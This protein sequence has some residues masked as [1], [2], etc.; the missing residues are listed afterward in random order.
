MSKVGIEAEDGRSRVFT[1]WS[2]QEV[3]PFTARDEPG[4]LWVPAARDR[5]DHTLGRSSRRWH[6]INLEAIGGEACPIESAARRRD[7]SWRR[8]HVGA[9]AG[10]EIQEPELAVTV[11][12]DVCEPL[13][14]ER[15][16]TQGG[17]EVG[18]TTRTGTWLQIQHARSVF[19]LAPVICPGL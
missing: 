12:I 17:R 4:R 11:D 15:D 3:E 8:S 13:L 5:C 16:V 9:L 10:L 7:V 19:E 18:Y 14:V 1:A 6:S 2:D